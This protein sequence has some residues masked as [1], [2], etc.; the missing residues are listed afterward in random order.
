MNTLRHA[1]KIRGERNKASTYQDRNSIIKIAVC[2]CVV[3]QSI[4]NTLHQLSKTKRHVYRMDTHFCCLDRRRASKKPNSY[5]RTD[6][7]HSLDNL[8]HQYAEVQKN[9]KRDKLPKNTGSKKAMPRVKTWQSY[10]T[11]RLIQFSRM[12]TRN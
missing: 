8:D 2:T 5:V 10:H 1:M 9:N 3:I 12:L 11:F 6:E 7:S 4:S